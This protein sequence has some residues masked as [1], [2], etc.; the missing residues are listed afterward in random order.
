MRASNRRVF[1]FILCLSVAAAL[2][3]PA[4]AFAAANVS[5]SASISAEVHNVL[6][7]EYDTPIR[8][9][10]LDTLNYAVPRAQ[11]SYTISVRNQTA[12]TAADNVTVE[13]RV[14]ANLTF[15]SASG[16]NFTWNENART[17]TWAEKTIGGGRR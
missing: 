3:V 2:L 1:A 13:F 11:V 15:V 17:V 5:V 14:P 16:E 12:R 6:S 9:D 8:E 7:E 4:S 10:L